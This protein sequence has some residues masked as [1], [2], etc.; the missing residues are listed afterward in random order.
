MFIRDVH[1]LEAQP[2]AQPSLEK[3]P[4]TGGSASGCHAGDREFDS[5]RTNSLVSYL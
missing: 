4:R 3:I 5:V 1:I 2:R